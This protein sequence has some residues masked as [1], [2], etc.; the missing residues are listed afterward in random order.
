MDASQEGR[1][2]SAPLLRPHG[3]DGQKFGHLSGDD[4]FSS[5]TLA[6]AQIHDLGVLPHM[7]NEYDI[8]RMFPKIEA[9]PETAN[10]WDWIPSDEDPAV[11][12]AGARGVMRD[13][14]RNTTA[15]KESENGNRP[16]CE[17]LIM[18][19]KSRSRVDEVAQFQSLRNSLLGVSR[20]G[21]FRRL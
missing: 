1:A 8:E 15:E 5:F 12:P 4:P 7:H 13:E 2:A 19:D 16:K 20:F 21:G 9:T 6:E 14:Y 10:S 18:P 11:G 17:R 3:V